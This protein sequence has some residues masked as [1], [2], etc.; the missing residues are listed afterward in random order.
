[1]AT[2]APVIDQQSAS[3][4]NAVIT[5]TWTGF[6]TSGDVGTPITFSAWSDKTWVVTGTFTGSLAITFQGSNDGVN[7]APLTG[8]AG[9]AQ[10]ATTAATVFTSADRPVYVRP[11]ATAGTGGASVTVSVACHRIDLIGKGA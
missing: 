7:W 2:I 5:A 10:T 9:G 11:L 3:S 4:D 8:R 6:A 1:M